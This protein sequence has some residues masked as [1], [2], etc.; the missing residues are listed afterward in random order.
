MRN[1]TFF[2]FS[3]FPLSD[4]P[5]C[6]LIFWLLSCKQVRSFVSGVCT[7]TEST[8]CL[9]F[10]FRPSLY[11]FANSSFLQSFFLC[12]KKY[13]SSLF[14]E[15]S[16]P[17]KIHLLWISFVFFSHFRCSVFSISLFF[18]SFASTSH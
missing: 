12:K 15:D 10:A 8:T 13:F 6:D 9:L 11:P 16:F 18:P 3:S 17:L 5:A 4:Y 7:I 2:K 14:D 1:L